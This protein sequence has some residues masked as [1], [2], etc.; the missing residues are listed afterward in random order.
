MLGWTE[1]MT[2]YVLGLFPSYPSLL[3]WSQTPRVTLLWTL[4]RHVTPLLEGVDR[5]GSA[6]THNGAELC[7]RATGSD[8][9]HLQHQVS[10]LR[11]CQKIPMG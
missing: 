3:V 2:L 4:K 9:H 11:L 6:F 8:H 1:Q 7:R 10:Q 5:L